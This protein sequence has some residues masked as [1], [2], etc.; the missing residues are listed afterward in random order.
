MTQVM[1]IVNV[2]PDSFSDGGKYF[3]PEEAIRRA[4]N[5]VAEGAAF[6]DFGAESTG[7][8]CFDNQVPSLLDEE[9]ALL[10]GRTSATAFPRMTEAPLY[11]RLAWN[12]TKG[13]SEGE[14]A[15]VANYGIRARDGVLDVNCAAAQ[16]PQGH[17]DAWGHYLSALT[18]YYRLLR[19][20]YF[21]WAAAMGEMLMDQKLMNVDYQDEQK[22]AD[23]A[24]KLVQT[25]MDAMDLTM[26]K[27]YKENGG[28][29]ERGTATSTPTTSRLSAMANGPRAPAW[30]PPT[31][32]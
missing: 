28:N 4:R 3:S 19:N 30:R 8:F 29:G 31:T 21:D 26:R 6:V 17:G 2:T 11:N 25:G 15:Y 5:V 32:G 27:A 18:G 1:G 13:I 16:Y 10:R 14:P 20:P 12:L 22:F 23:A 7:L 9:L 24:V